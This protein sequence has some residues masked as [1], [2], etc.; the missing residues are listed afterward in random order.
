[1]N[2][3][4]HQ[5]V[6]PLRTGLRLLLSGLFLFAGTM[7]FVKPDGYVAIV[8]R[9]LP[10]PRGLVFISGVAEILGGIGLLLP[11]PLR[12][13]AGW[14]LILLLLAVFPAN[15]EM[16]RHPTRIGNLTVTP[17]WALVRLPFQ[18]VLIAW[19]WWCAIGRFYG[20]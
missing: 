7:H 11:P 18:A 13:W 2:G 9:Y 5:F 17:F 12:R 14:G 16:A 15:V 10:D 6:R 8:P 1:M 3:K 4:P 20:E 19:V